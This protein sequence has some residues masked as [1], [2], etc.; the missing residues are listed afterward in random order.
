MKY[1]HLTMRPLDNA[2][3]LHCTYC[4]IQ[5]QFNANSCRDDQL[6]MWKWFPHLL[7]QMSLSKGLHAVTFGWHGGEP[8]LLPRELLEKAAYW[9]SQYL[10]NIHYHNFIQTNGLLLDSACADFLHRIGFDITVSIDGPTYQHNRARCK[11]VRLF[12]KILSNI[13]ALKR[14]N[15]PF[16]ICMVVHEDN[17]SDTG[18]IMDFLLEI[19]PKNG[20]SFTPRFNDARS[21]I[22]PISFGDFL[23]NIFDLWWPECEF[24]IG[25]FESI[26]S[27]IKREVP[28]VCFLCGGCQSFINIDS[29]GDVYST[30]W[31]INANTRAGNI[32]GDPLELI[33]S[34]H[35]KRIQKWMQNRERKSLFQLLGSKIPYI[36]FQSK[37]CIYRILVEGERDPYLPAYAKL[38]KFIGKKIL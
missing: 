25:L 19:N 37:G 5:S 27:G 32:L 6:H 9:Q 1:L 38:I 31:L 30:C 7:E 13:Q 36:Y 28:N 12:E 4:S 23:I 33:I 16:S 14:K 22:N 10:K 18:G 35:I 21:I 29:H 15:L 11:N 3:N 2:C 24:S 17:F 20:V 34:T 8:L 26:I